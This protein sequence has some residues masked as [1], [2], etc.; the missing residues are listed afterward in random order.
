MMVTGQQS[1]IRTKRGRSKVS[2]TKRETESDYSI[3]SKLEAMKLVITTA[4]DKLASCVGV[5]NITKYKVLC[6]RITDTRGAIEQLCRPSLRDRYVES[7]RR[8]QDIQSKT[9][10]PQYNKRRRSSA[11]VSHVFSGD[12]EDRLSMRRCEKQRSLLANRKSSPRLNSIDY[13]DKC[14]VERI[15][16]RECA[17]MVCPRCGTS[18]FF[19]AHILDTKESEDNK[20]KTTASNPLT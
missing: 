13:C 8:L 15:V 5:H 6:R 2:R 20:K 3:E 7:G 12:H 11:V 9:M 17:N 19:A 16:T 10:T 14:N 4:E 1:R 18:S